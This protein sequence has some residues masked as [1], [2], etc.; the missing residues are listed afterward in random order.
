[1]PRIL[2]VEDEP[3]ISYGLELD[4]KTEG[5]EVELVEDGETAVRRGREG[6]FDVIVL[7]LML[8]KK[9]GFEV[10]RE[11]R[12]GG[13]RTPILMLTAR[14]Q[15]AEKVMG[16]DLGADDY[17]TKPFSPKELRARVRALLRRGAGDE[18]E[19]PY[20]FSDV[21]VDFARGEVR[22]GGTVV[23]MT[24]LEFKLLGAFVKNRGRVLSRSRLLDLVWGPG[25]FV[26]DRVVDNYIVT[27]RRKLEPEPALPRLLMNVRGQ[28]YR[29][30]G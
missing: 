21:E 20:R 5:Y 10:C 4:L 24:P 16:L 28:G 1:M 7:D 2:I 27:L 29:F 6:A 15:E 17:V 23:E 12:R 22:R 25:T 13:I 11:L 8:P 9:D 18:A 14:S 3:A 30:D 26:T 19:E